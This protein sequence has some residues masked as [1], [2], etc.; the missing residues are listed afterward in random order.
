[1]PNIKKKPYTNILDQSI[2]NSKSRIINKIHHIPSLTERGHTL[3]YFFIT[4][5]KQANN[6]TTMQV[7]SQK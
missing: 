4:G 2:V 7:V 5:N 3:N 6:T 1:M